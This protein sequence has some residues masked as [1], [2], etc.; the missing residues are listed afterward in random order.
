MVSDIEGYVEFT[1]HHRPCFR[2]LT[3]ADVLV[4]VLGEA[5]PRLRA[6]DIRLD[7]T[8]PAGLPGIYGDPELLHT[9]FFGLVE[10]ACDAMPQGGQLSLEVLHCDPW[11]VVRIRDT[12]VGIPE[13]DLAE[14]FD[15]FVTSKTTGAGLGLAKAYIIVEEHSGRIEFD[16]QVGRGTTCTVSLPID[17][18]RVPR[19]SVRCPVEAS[20]S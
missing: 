12:G 8:P 4:T 11:A 15:P 10:N 17:R 9:L 14:I 6:A 2:P 20:S 3:L 5:A 1:K 7:F 16:S 13:A 18:R 19:A